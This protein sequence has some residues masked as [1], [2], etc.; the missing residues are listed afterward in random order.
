MEKSYQEIDTPINGVKI[1][2]NKVNSDSRGHF[3]DLA[4][5]DNPLFKDIKHLHASVA[6][7][8]YVARGEHYHYKLT[9]NFYVLSGTSLF[10]M[11]DFNEDSPT[12]GKTYALI[13]GNGKEKPNTN[14]ETYYIDEGRLAQIS[15]SPKVYHAF[16]PL[17]DDDA[18]IFVT[19]NTG[20]DAQDYG[21]PKIEEVPGA[22]EILKQ[23]GII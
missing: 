12:Y 11:H 21:K 15:I 13:L 10:I 8:K 4:E 6:T 9:E 7:T 1:L 5:T 3:L 14:L 18:V 20:Y 16:W 19:G 22:V 17:T 23:H 2:L